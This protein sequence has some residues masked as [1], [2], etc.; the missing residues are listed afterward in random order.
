ME[1]P[2]VV[3]STF[4][5]EAWIS[6]TASIENKRPSDCKDKETVVYLVYTTR[7]GIKEFHLYKPNQLGKLEL[8]E[9]MNEFEGRFCNPFETIKTLAK[10][11]KA[12]AIDEFQESI[13]NVMCKAF[14]ELHYIL[15]M[16]VFLSS[17]PKQVSVRW[18]PD[19]EWIDKDGLHQQIK[20][21][22]Q[23]SQNIAFMLEYPAENNLVKMLLISDENQEVFTYEI[24]ESS[25]TLNYISREPYDGEYSGMFLK[26][27]KLND[28]KDH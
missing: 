27:D 11:E 9:I 22:C 28:L 1:N 19:E 10:S 24:D 17:K 20:T 14:K 5:C 23:D 25:T 2:N 4:Y 16:I 8:V 6:E 15:P 21:K 12:R 26:P 7:D 3:A 18:I 13:R